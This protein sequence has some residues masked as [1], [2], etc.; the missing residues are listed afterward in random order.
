MLVRALTKTGKYLLYLLAGL[1]ILVALLAAFARL[2]VFYGEDYS[3]RLASVV[4][5]YI[6][7]PVQ[8]SDIDLV[9]DRFDASASLSDVRILTEDG[10]ETLLVLPSIELELNLRDMLLQRNLTVRNIQLKNL[11]LLAAYEG[12]GKLKIQGR[13]ITGSRS[14]PESSGNQ[15]GST[16]NSASVNLN[17]DDLH[18]EAKDGEKGGIGQRGHSALSWLFNAERI[19]ILESDITLTDATRDKTYRIDNVDIRAFNSGDLHQIRISSALP[20]AMGETSVASF[21][22]TGRS[23]DVNDWSGQFYVDAKRLNLSEISDF[24]RDQH[25]R[26]NGTADVQLWGRWRGTRINQVRAIMNGKDLLMGL[27]MSDS[28]QT[29]MLEADKIELDLDWNRTEAG[30]DSSFNRLLI[31]Y[32]GEPEKS[33]RLD[34][35]DLFTQRDENGDRQLRMAGPD[36]SI[37]Q[38]RP[39]L[40]FARPFHSKLAIVD[41]FRDGVMRDW[42]I[43]GT[44]QSGNLNLAIVKAN[45]EK[46]AFDP[47]PGTA[48]SKASPGVSGLSAEV[49]FN[50]DAGYLNLKPQSLGFLAPDLFD[51]PLPALDAQGVV[52]FAKKGDEWIVAAEHVKVGSVDIATDT[53]FRL[54]LNQYG[55]PLLDLNTSVNHVNLAKVHA[56]YPSKVIKPT[57]LDWLNTSIIDG[58]V[59]RGQ[60]TLSGDLSDFSPAQN[61]GVFFG[62][63]D[64]VD[65]TLDFKAG[66]PRA[67]D[68][69]GNLTFNTQSMRGRVYQGAMRK[70]RFSDARLY[71]ADLQ[72]PVLDFQTNAIGPLDDMLDFAQRGPLAEEIGE[73]F[74][75]ATGGGASRLELDVAIPL[76]GELDDQLRVDG[77][78]V[79]ENAQI[80][81]AEFGLDLESVTGEVSFNQEGVEFDGLLVRYLGVPVRVDAVQRTVG[82]KQINTISVNGPVSIASVLQSY[83]VPLTEPFEGLSDWQVRLDITRRGEGSKAQVELTATSDL[84]GTTIE[85]PVPFD[86]PS[87]VLMDAKVY[88]NFTAKESDWWVEL[89]GLAQG[90]LRLDQD[91]ELESMAIALGSSNN[92][93]LPWSGI[94]VHGDVVRLDALGWLNFGLDLE[95]TGDQS[96][97]SEFPLFANVSARSMQTGSQDIGAG[98]YIAYRD[99]PHQVHRIENRYANGELRRLLNP[100]SEDPLVVRLDHLDKKLFEALKAAD[101]EDTSVTD[102]SLD[103]RTIPPLDVIVKELKWDDWRFSRVALR[104]QPEDRGLVIAGLTAR[105]KSMRVSGNGRWEVYDAG[106]VRSH[107]TTLDLNATFDNFGEGI[108]A[109][110]GGDTFAEGQGEVALSIGWPDAGYAPDLENM[111]GELF[112]SMRNGRILGIEPGAGRI[113]G[114]FALQALPRRLTFDFRDIVRTGLEYTTINGSFSIANGLAS[115]Q[116]LLLTGPV[117]EILVHGSSDFVNRIYD[118]TVDVLPRVSG[119]LPLIGVLS[120]GPAAGVTALVADGILKGL[121][122]NLDEIGRRRYT[123]TG[124]WDAPNWE[125]VNLQAGR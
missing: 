90:R 62:E 108:N 3:E 20:D 63:V 78:V 117:A 44:V 67:T 37:A 116:T 6:G 56:Y 119:A 9:W 115:S 85:L 65:S 41:R 42:V 11:S 79:L 49:Y 104:T 36:I 70:A 60:V 93:V 94:A 14:N 101:A 61:K 68:M 23:D 50:N 80:N 40:S 121:G 76:K 105:Q 46:F 81:A 86:K 103:P 83:E 96:S 26:Y 123:L 72:N 15:T 25:Q 58:S 30:W 84:S 27:P 32:N 77:K 69:D 21:D 64:I 124:P 111:T 38:L 75:D 1:L 34:G 125:T 99:G 16:D 35:L 12:H 5:R 53:S 10:T 97:K 89:P 109:L 73:F 51:E 98:M 74:G 106:S 114:L 8:I 100:D 43:G 28:D 54:V 107:A 13:G 2:A 39:L 66:W 19:A 22:F 110:G 91:G 48:E 88:R 4:S 122:V 31:D 57:L 120:G 55:Q 33:L 24:W 112:F 95:E 52:R 71:I 82:A 29:A 102:R 92:T 113:L 45:L 18:S 47:L 17:T 87:D 118:Q 59:V 7:S